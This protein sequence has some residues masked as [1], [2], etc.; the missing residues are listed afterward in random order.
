MLNQIR[1][2][3]TILGVI[4]VAVG[5]L[6]SSRLNGP[7]EQY[8]VKRFPTNILIDREGKVVGVLALGEMKAALETFNAL[9]KA[10]N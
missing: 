10:R 4:V 5:I 1:A 7:V 8:G 6:P 3:A 9:L 2:Y